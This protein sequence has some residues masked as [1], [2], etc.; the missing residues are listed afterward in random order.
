MKVLS[1]NPFTEARA[2]GH[3]IL[4]MIAMVVLVFT[5]GACSDDDEEVTVEFPQL[6]ELACN[7]GE[8]AS[9]TFN[10]P[11]DWQ[12][13]SS[14]VWCKFVTSEEDAFAV[15]GAAGAQ[16]VTI[17]ADDEAY[18][19]EA[20]TANITLTMGMKKAVIAKVTRSAQGYEL[21]VFNAEGQE[22]KEIE[23]GYGAFAHFT[24]EAN[25]R[26]A[27]TNRPAWVEIEGGSMSGVAGQKTQ[28]GLRIIENGIVEKYPV[29][30]ADKQLL[31]FADEE[32]KASF[33]FPLTFKG[34]NPKDITITG[35]T[36]NPW[37]WTVSLDGK[38]F[39]QESA[40]GLTG[41]ASKT[42]YKNRLPYT[43][44]ALNDDYEIVYMQK[45]ELMPGM[46]NYAIG[47]AE[48]VDWMKFDKKT[49]SLSVNATMEEREGF[50]LAFPTA[51]YD[52]IKDD[53]WGNLIESTADMETGMMTQEL[54][55]EYAENNLL[56]NFIQKEKK[57]EG[58]GEVEGP[59]VKVT[60]MDMEQGIMDAEAPLT[61]CEDEG[62]IQDLGT[63]NIYYVDRNL[64]Q[65]FFIDP[66][67][68]GEWEYMAF[69]GDEDVT[70]IC[71]LMDGKLN[72]W[73]GD[74]DFPV[75]AEIQ[76]IFKQNWMNERVVIIK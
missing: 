54:K 49:M 1:M 56:L 10:A 27:A 9:L 61:K 75:G 39:V 26:F 33:I 2:K 43:I 40:S 73:T 59:N 76:V 46:Y 7:V 67:L 22:V 53:L 63:E 48:G 47:E 70:S 41:E 5:M 6:Q 58:G 34:M 3:N 23:V 50:V 44:K 42:I 15:S 65:S 11:T 45:V 66:M 30:A 68:E 60:Y 64:T 69:L 35:V 12:L 18:G 36:N 8:T 62:L 31:V 52:E 25:F 4:R 29:A 51:V 72:V 28:G 57:E 74:I 71:E 37:D 21:K 38:T 13:T 14:A 24:V 32:G 17:K 55:Y 19:H 16:T 20:A